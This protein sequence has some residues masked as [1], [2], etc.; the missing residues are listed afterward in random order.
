VK[1]RQDGQ[2]QKGGP[3]DEISHMSSKS[4]DPNSR[5]MV[6]GHDEPDNNHGNPISVAHMVGMNLSGSAK[7]N[8]YR[9]NSQNN[10]AGRTYGGGHFEGL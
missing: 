4:S 10:T 5:R 2:R 6:K 8:K 3:G 9:T 1:K 7:Q